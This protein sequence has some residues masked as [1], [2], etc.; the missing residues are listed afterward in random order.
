MRIAALPRS[1]IV[2][3]HLAENGAFIREGALVGWAQLLGHTTVVTIH[4]S[5]FLPFAQRRR[6]L[7]S[8][9]LRHAHLITC[10]DESVLDLVRQL[11]PQAHAVIVPNPV[12]IDDV[13]ST[14]EETEEVV[15]FAGLIGMR[16]GADVL[17]RAWELVARS[18]PD[19]RCIVVGPA[20]DF[21]VPQLERLE[22]REPVDADEIRK[23]IRSARVVTL[24]SRAEGMPMILTEAMSVGRPFVSTPVGGIPALAHQG[25]A[26]VAVGDHLALARRLTEL[27]ANPTLA[28]DIGE[29]GRRFCMRTRGVEVLDTRLSEL[30]A[31]AA[32]VEA[33]RRPMRASPSR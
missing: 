19:A 11:A 13:F 1:D 22:V 15:L 20:G 7:A 27:L 31:E 28:A 5:G 17:S 2:H 6:R 23:L 4:G 9:V 10:L 3:V 18:R 16:K 26:L 8:T 30:Y 29:R 12:A 32:R 14:A 25:G 33:V 24:P 21:T